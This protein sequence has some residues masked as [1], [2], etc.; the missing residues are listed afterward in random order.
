MKLAG[1]ITLR[2]LCK[3]EVER[4][5]AVSMPEVMV[6][7]ISLVADPVTDK[8]QNETHFLE[9]ECFE[10]PVNCDTEQNSLC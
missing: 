5:G 6:A 2:K 9:S 1:C 3:E 10:V 8:H 7:W 4:S